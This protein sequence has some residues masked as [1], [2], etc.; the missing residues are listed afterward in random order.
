LQFLRQAKNRHFDYLSKLIEN[1]LDENS[2]SAQAEKYTASITRAKFTKFPNSEI[3]SHNW[4]ETMAIGEQ[5]IH[6]EKIAAFT[7]AGREWMRLGRV[8]PKG[9]FQAKPS[10]QKT[11]LSNICGKDKSCRTKA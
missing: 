11:I 7:V 1:V 10:K 4:K 5:I 3:D 9:T 2:L 6:D 8:D